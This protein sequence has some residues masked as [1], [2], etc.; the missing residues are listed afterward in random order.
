MN[1]ES[2][3]NCRAFSRRSNKMR[4][5]DEA[6]Q[7][8]RRVRIWWG[9]LDTPIDWSGAS[10]R[11]CEV[12]KRDQLI[13]LFGWNERVCRYFSAE[14]LRQ[15]KYLCFYG[16]VKASVYTL[17]ITLKRKE[18]SGSNKHEHLLG[19]FLVTC[20]ELCQAV[21]AFESLRDVRFSFH[22]G[23]TLAQD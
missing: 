18:Y 11:E 21:L 14:R 22:R 10:S 3:P 9:T 19:Y 5:W 2:R 12:G 7:M 17:F 13:W 20:W 4:P 8:K 15:L 16:A 23:I 1:R 6:S